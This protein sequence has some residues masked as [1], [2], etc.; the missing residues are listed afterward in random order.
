MLLHP[1][2]NEYTIMYNILQEGRNI[3]RLFIFGSP[4]DNVGFAKGVESEMRCLSHK[5][6]LF[7]ITLEETLDNIRTIVIAKKVL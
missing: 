5:V 1:Y 2:A 7:Y 6:E 3:A 4:S